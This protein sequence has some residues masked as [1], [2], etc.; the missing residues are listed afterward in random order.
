MPKTEIIDINALKRFFL[1]IELRNNVTVM[2]RGDIFQG[3]PHVALK[4]KG[5]LFHRY[6]FI[7]SNSIIRHQADLIILNKGFELQITE[8]AVIFINLNNSALNFTLPRSEI[9][10]INAFLKVWPRAIPRLSIS[11]NR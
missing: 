9:L 11:L 4:I 5:R 2:E 3:V 10:S 1:A 7:N 8:T 6:K